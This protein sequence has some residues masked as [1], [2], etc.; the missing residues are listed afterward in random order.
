M[1]ASG[2]SAAR[3]RR[4]SPRVRGIGLPAQ[5]RKVLATGAVGVLLTLVVVH[6]A[7][8]GLHRVEDTSQHVAQLDSARGA[9]QDA[10]M[11][12]DALYA[13]VLAASLTDGTDVPGLPEP[14]EEVRQDAERFRRN[15]RQVDGVALPAR[16]RDAVVRVRPLQE[17]YIVEAERLVDPRLAPGERVAEL[18]AFR[19]AFVDLRQTQDLITA[20]LAAEAD[21][22]RLVARR[23]QRDAQ[24]W[25]V[26]SSAGALMGLVALSTW[27]SRVV[28][29]LAARARH[30]RGVAETLQRML[31]PDVLPELPGVRMSAQ[32]LPTTDSALVGGDWYDVLALPGGDI[33]LVMGDVAGHDLRAASEMGQLRN[34]LRAYAADGAQPA[35]VLERLN[36]L[37]FQQALAVM[38]T[39]LYAV[40]DPVAGELTVVNAG[41]LPPLLVHPERGAAQYLD[42]SSPQPP[43]GAVR[44]P[45]YAPVRHQLPPQSV[46]LL[47]TDGLL[48]RRGVSMEDGLQLLAA[49]AAQGP[50]DLEAL[51]D[52][53]LQRMF[54]GVPPQDDV[55]MLA[56][57]P[58]V[59]LGDHVQLTCLAAP[60][61]LLRLRRTLQRW[62]DEAGASET[63]AYEITVAASE[64]ATNA[65]EHAYGP[66]RAYFEVDCRRAGPLVTVG[67]RDWG[68]WRPP[69]G[70]DRGRGIMLMEALMDDA[71]VEHGANGTVV[72]LRRR[73]HCAEHLEETG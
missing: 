35:A 61:S 59:R 58:D 29:A 11:M 60:A 65:I 62:L 26:V 30:E 63:E 34:A 54:D 18:P 2:V 3:R 57:A 44:S 23:H 47:F 53:V 20:S 7:L 12:H 38:A 73:L 49:T 36:D 48:E 9:F 19:R 10:D 46:V 28:R 8:L 40:L 27:L 13:G 42:G 21:R 52:H 69:R 17:A 1:K 68:S 31:L 41:H 24:E 56:V 14:V 55:A 5:Q 71:E 70:E 72:R 39:V 15:L 64:A 4:W 51:V 37:C 50:H 6:A 67:V 25:I 16:I 32:Y 43:V 33:G 66:G 45:H 22:A